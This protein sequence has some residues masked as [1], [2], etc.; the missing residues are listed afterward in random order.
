MIIFILPPTPILLLG[1]WVEY[2]FANINLHIV[3]WIVADH[4]W[5]VIF[6]VYII[7]LYLPTYFLAPYDH[8]LLHM[9]KCLNLN[10]N[11]TMFNPIICCVLLLN[12]SCNIFSTHGTFLN[13]WWSCRHSIKKE[14]VLTHFFLKYSNIMKTQ[15]SNL[16]LNPPF[17]VASEEW[18]DCSSL[19]CIT[20][21]LKEWN[22]Y[23]QN[24]K[25]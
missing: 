21:L 19:N 20:M 16:A 4:I 12:I 2:Y 13:W 1:P 14:K 10:N 18:W 25:I 3:K 23:F 8:V 15:N 24:D 6:F 17:A 7:I 5:K 11:H 9:I 22:V